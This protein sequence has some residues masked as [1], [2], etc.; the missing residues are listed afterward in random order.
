MGP[1]RPTSSTWTATEGTK[2][3]LAAAPRR[4]LLDVLHCKEGIDG[5]SPSEDFGI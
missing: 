4:R 5:S 1:E 3:D 2:K